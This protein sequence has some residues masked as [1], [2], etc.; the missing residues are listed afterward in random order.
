MNEAERLP[1]RMGPRWWR[2]Q[3]AFIGHPSAL[4]LGVLIAQIVL[5]PALLGFSAAPLVLDGIGIAA[6]LLALRLI[7]YT[8][9]FVWHAV[10]MAGVSIGLELLL[11]ITGSV[12]LIPWQAVTQAIL[13]FYTARCLIRYIL[14]DRRASLDELF[15]A[16]A[17]FMLLVWAFTELLVACQWLQPGAFAGTDAPGDLRSVN[18]LLFLSFAL[19]TSTGIGTVVPMTAAARV[20]G[21][22]EM[23]SG[24]MYLALVISRLVGM[25]AN[26]GVQK[27]V[28][29]AAARSDD[30]ADEA[31]RHPPVGTGR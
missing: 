3:I 26:G 19:F 20:I 22:L 29:K 31:G 28:P 9:G 15:A 17:A 24:V 18:E 5:Y 13:Y 10:A 11:V 12:R 6:L 21:D 25:A 23:F 14:V 30:D 4:L 27:S 2:R 7:H 8:R 1:K 16:A